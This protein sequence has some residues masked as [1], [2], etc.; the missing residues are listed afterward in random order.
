MSDNFFITTGTLYVHFNPHTH[1]Y[2]VGNSKHGACLFK[3]E[4]GLNFIKN[5][6]N[7]DW[8][9][10][11]IGDKCNISVIKKSRKYEKTLYDKLH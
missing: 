2:I 6:L 9:L 3:K 7:S 10:E 4:I 1:A 8:K 5:G 11:S